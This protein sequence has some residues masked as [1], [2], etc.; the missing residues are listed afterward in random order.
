MDEVIVLTRSDRISEIKAVDQSWCHVVGIPDASIYSLR[1][2][3]PTISQNDWLVVLEEHSLVTI[4]T[5]DAIRST[6]QN[7]P[8][9]DLIVF[10]GK[11]LTSVS[12]WGWANFLHT[13]ALIW[14]PIDGPPPFSPVTSAI[15]RRAALGTDVALREG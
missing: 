10:L 6:I 5:L 4:T 15:V 9:I 1:A 12:P 8:D 2:R 11:N 14:A 7:Q 3:I 13:F